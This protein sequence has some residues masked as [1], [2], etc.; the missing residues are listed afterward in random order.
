MSRKFRY[1]AA[2]GR[3]TRKGQLE[4]ECCTCRPHQIQKNKNTQIL[5]VMLIKRATLQNFKTGK[6]NSRPNVV[7]VD[8]AKIQKHKKPPP[9][10][11]KN[12]KTGKVNLR[13]S[14][15]CWPWFHYCFPLAHQ[16]TMSKI[17]T[18]QAIIVSRSTMWG[19][20]PNKKNTD[21]S[22]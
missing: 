6:V 7:L 3:L 12:T 1:Q 22:I 19:N 16:W 8:L 13:L 20:L 9:T 18:M 2:L 14:C 15:T 10:H 4:T 21:Y 17:L 11:K 5:K